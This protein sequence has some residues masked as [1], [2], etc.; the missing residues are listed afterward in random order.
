MTNATGIGPALRRARLLRNKSIEEASRETRIRAEYL[1]AM[2]RER[3]DDLLGEVY[4]RGFLRTYAGYLGLDADKV[5]AVYT[6][7]SGAVGLQTRPWPGEPQPT[8]TADAP[9]ADRTGPPVEV[10]VTGPAAP[11]RPA[12]DARRGP[13]RGGNPFRPSTSP[14]TFRRRRLNWPVMIGVAFTVLIILATAGLFSRAKTVPPQAGGAVLPP[15][16]EAGAG[17]TLAVE[18]TVDV[19]MTVAADGQVVYQR[20]L[21]AGEGASF[22]GEAT[23]SI[24]LGRG[25]SA[26]LTVNGHDLGSP[27]SPDRPFHAIY[28]PNDFRRRPSPGPSVG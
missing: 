9:S 21:R 1:Q 3:F 25:A 7:G 22:H 19:R 16:G 8:G 11:T 24:T 26:N 5:I 4:A 10:A 18:G 27:G 12:R 17:V 6:G 14:P 20:T 13:F 23:I 2:E 15:A 28:G